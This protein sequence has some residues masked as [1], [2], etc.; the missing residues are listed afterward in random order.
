MDSGWNDANWGLLLHQAWRGSTQSAIP[1]FPNPT[2]GC[3]PAFD[4]EKD[5]ALDAFL[6]QRAFPSKTSKC[7]LTAVKIPGGC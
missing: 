2:G 5:W 6:D 3:A 7:I 1:A 4:S